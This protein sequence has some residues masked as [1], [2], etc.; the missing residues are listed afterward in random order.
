MFFFVCFLHR[1]ILSQVFNVEGF[2]L[3]TDTWN[4]SFL[5]FTQIVLLLHSEWGVQETLFTQDTEQPRTAAVFCFIYFN[6]NPSPLAVCCG[7]LW[8]SGVLATV[9]AAVDR[10]FKRVLKA[11]MVAFMCVIVTNPKVTA[12]KWDHPSPG[13]PA[14]CR[15]LPNWFT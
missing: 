14:T 1:S 10:D 7:L 11:V 9:A 4:W 5:T 13:R 8:C 15:F 6:A 3:E 2:N 12:S